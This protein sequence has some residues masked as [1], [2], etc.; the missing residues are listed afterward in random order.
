MLIVGLGDGKCSAY[1]GPD[2]VNRSFAGNCTTNLFGGKNCTFL[3]SVLYLVAG[4]N[5]SAPLGTYV[6]PDFQKWFDAIGIGN[7][8]TLSTLQHPAPGPVFP[9]PS[10]LHFCLCDRRCAL[11]L[12]AVFGPCLAVSEFPVVLTE[13][14]VTVSS[15]GSG[16]VVIMALLLLKWWVSP[17]LCNARKG[18]LVASLLKPVPVGCLRFFL[19]LLPLNLPFLNF[20]QP[21]TFVKEGRNLMIYKILIFSLMTQFS[22][23]LISAAL[24]CYIDATGSLLKLDA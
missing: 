16:E 17:F 6:P 4:N 20:S 23:R 14:H 12:P 2:G 11:H 8:T 19:H 18:C 24:R 21:L 9:A 13:C 1:W 10:S 3:G 7:V 5:V 22:L 15:W